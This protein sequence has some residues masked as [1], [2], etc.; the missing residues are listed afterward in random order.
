MHVKPGTYVVAVSGGVDSVVLLDLLNQK[1]GLNLH[2]AHYDHGIRTDSNQD[3]LLVERLARAYSLPFFSA[4]GQLGSKASEATARDKRYAFLA[5]VK[6]QV[7]ADAIITAHHQDDWIETAMLNILRGTGRRGLSS[8]QNSGELI[9]PLL[10]V[11]KTDIIA[12]AHERKLVW[13]EDSTNTDEQYARNYVR[14]RIMPKLSVSGRQQFLAAMQKAAELNEVIDELLQETV[15]QQVVDGELDRQW[16]ISLPHAV[17]REVLLTWLRQAGASQL[18]RRHIER[19]VVLAKT[20]PHG[21]LIDVDAGLQ[22]Q[23]TARKL[24]LVPRER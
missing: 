6:K 21:K 5:D 14:Q 11:P 18:D 1:S 24:A 17:A 12:Y 9:R 22:L 15:S 3:A 19:L 10:G 8:L 4:A 2:V 13:R 16:F 23:V 20:L 7:A